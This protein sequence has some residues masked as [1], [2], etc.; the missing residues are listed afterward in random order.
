MLEGVDLRLGV[1]EGP[2]KR[3]ALAFQLPHAEQ[4]RLR[5]ELGVAQGR[6]DLGVLGLELAEGLLESGDLTSE[7]P[8]AL[9]LSVG[10]SGGLGFGVEGGRQ[11]ADVEAR[12]A[13]R[14]RRVCDKLAE[15]SP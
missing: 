1:G 3:G 14:L 13:G 9:G 8:A 12:I 2:N 5:V 11:V 10:G 6:R 15:V 4:P 7:R